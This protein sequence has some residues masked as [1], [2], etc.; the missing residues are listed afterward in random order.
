MDKILLVYHATCIRLS[1]RHCH[2]TDLRR[3]VVALACQ[4][5]E[6]WC[7]FAGCP[8]LVHPDAGSVPPQCDVPERCVVMPVLHVPIGHEPG[9]SR[10]VHDVVKRDLAPA[11]ARP[12]VVRW[13]GPAPCGGHGLRRVRICKAERRDPRAFVHLY[14]GCTRVVEEQL[15]KIR[16]GLTSPCDP[17]VRNEPTEKNCTEGDGP[18]SRHYSHVSPQS[19]YLSPYDAVHKEVNVQ[20]R[21]VEITYILRA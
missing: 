17:R 10:R 16:S 12:L 21:V 2:V 6:P 19:P 8:S 3:R 5:L 11:L 18:R 20:M 4:R 1:H 13:V 15:V 14:P 7:A 9:P